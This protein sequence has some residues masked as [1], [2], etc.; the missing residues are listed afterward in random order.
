M[1]PFYNFNNR[2]Q[3]VDRAGIPVMRTIYVSTSADNEQV[4]Y[5][6]CPLQWRQLPSEGIILLNV[7]HTP[8]STATSGAAVLIDPT[9][10]TSRASGSNNISAGGKSLLNGSG[11]QM[12][13]EEV[14]SG[15]RYFVYYNKCTGTF[16]AI[17]HIVVPAAP[18]A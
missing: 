12:V 9:T 17:N 5:G 10:T 15:N 1:Y 2:V 3:R 6:I 11:D 16:Q 18:A 7:Q 13:N 8:A 14:T 4:T